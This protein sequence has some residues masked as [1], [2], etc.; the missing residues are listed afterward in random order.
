MTTEAGPDAPQSV[1]AGAWTPELRQDF[2][3]HVQSWYDQHPEL[4]EQLQSNMQHFW[5][6]PEGQK[7]RGEMSAAATAGA[8]DQ[9]A[10]AQS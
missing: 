10:R 2:Q 5:E 4:K 8:Q 7:L 6:S 9:G 1:N 3:R